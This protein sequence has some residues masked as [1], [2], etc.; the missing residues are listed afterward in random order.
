VKKWLYP[1]IGAVLVTATVTGAAFA[2][3]GGEDGRSS[4]ENGASQDQGDQSQDD[5]RPDAGS[6]NDDAVSS[7]DAISHHDTD[8]MTAEEGERRTELAPIEGVDLRIAESFPPQY[9][10][11]VTYG[12]PSGC[13]KPGG[14]EVEQ[15]GTEV[16]V[17]VNISLPADPN[18][19]CTMIYGIAT[20][21]VPLGSDFQ[22][23][24]TYAVVVNGE[25]RTTF[26]AQ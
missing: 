9:F 13:A 1:L 12:L 20:G 5:Q 6:S 18:T 22:S 3:S 14:F 15:T 26:T 24:E 4:T 21:T 23:G 8:D 7:D 11:E 10:L 19:I 16:R 17:T 2:F 25:T